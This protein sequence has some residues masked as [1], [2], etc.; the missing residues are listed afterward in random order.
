M[1]TFDLSP[2]EDA[3]L[4][5]PP[6]L[7]VGLYTVSRA[8]RSEITLEHGKK[9]KSVTIEATNYSPANCSSPGRARAEQG[10]RGCTAPLS[11]P[12]SVPY[13]PDATRLVIEC[14]TWRPSE[15]LGTQDPREIALGIRTISLAST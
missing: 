10:R 9:Y 14:E 11:P 13:D 12:I 7:P 2:D 15:L 5:Q 1:S 8:R 4:G 6:I 3:V